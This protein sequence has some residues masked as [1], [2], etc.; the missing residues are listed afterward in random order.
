VF[1]TNSKLYL[2]APGRSVYSAL[3]ESVHTAD[4]EENQV[5]IP[6]FLDPI[7]KRFLL[8]LFKVL[9]YR[10]DIIDRDGN[11]TDPV[12]DE[13]ETPQSSP[14]EKQNQKRVRSESGNDESTSKKKSRKK[15][16][17]KYET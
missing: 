9:G 4:A 12:P 5:H 15:N 13:L 14:A 6:E 7:P 3:S 1:K 2:S 10:V 8:G 17:K 11:L 16:D